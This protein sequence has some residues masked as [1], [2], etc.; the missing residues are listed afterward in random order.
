MREKLARQ[1]EHGMKIVLK[2]IGTL[3]LVLGVSMILMIT[4][5]VTDFA[6]ILF[7]RK[8]YVADLTDACFDNGTDLRD[9]CA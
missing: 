7:G 5:F 9:V 6:L 4:P 2:N 1:Q 3:V 8:R